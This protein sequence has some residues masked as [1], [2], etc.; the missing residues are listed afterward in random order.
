MRYFE[1]IISSI[2]IIMCFE[3]CYKEEIIFNT[4]PN[5]LLELPL[6]LRMN[7]KDCFFDNNQNSLRYSVAEEAIPK[8][9]VFIEFQEYSVI[10]FEDHLLKNNQINNLGEIKINTEYKLQ[11]VTNNII[12][13]LTLICT[14]LPIVQIIT[15]NQIYDEPKSL[16]KIV[17]NYSDKQ[18]IISYIGIEQRGGWHTL[19]LPKRSYTF[20]FLNSI[21]TDDKISKSLFDLKMNSD[22]ILDGMFTD[23]IKVK[24]KIASKIWSDMPGDKHFGVQLN[25]VELFINNEHQGLYCLGE[26]INAELLSL[27]TNEAL[28]Y[29]AIGWTGPLCFETSSQDLPSIERWDGWIQKYPNPNQK[30]NWEPL[31]DLRDLIVDSSDEEFISQINDFIDIDNFIDYY[32]FL[33]LICATDNLGKNIFLT[34]ALESE[35]LCII[36][37]DFDLSFGAYWN[38]DVAWNTD[39]TDFSASRIIS[40]NRL[41]ERLVALNPINFNQKLKDRWAYLRNSIFST[42]HLLEIVEANLVQLQSSDIINIENNKWSSNINIQNVFEKLNLW[43]TERL[44]ILDNYYEDL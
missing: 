5:N 25:Y 6:I 21:Y 19:Q 18:A 10:F 4:E 2:L 32:L 20:S 33:N 40:N 30:I 28:L 37:W 39:V 12:T 36:P 7:H 26:K 3:S 15:P 31:A 23:N 14:N 35:P 44:P 22:W 27:S 38:A 17:V 11:V 9:E 13:E 29:K 1:I 41:Y 16:A 43:I 24:N 34:R 42:T 8:F